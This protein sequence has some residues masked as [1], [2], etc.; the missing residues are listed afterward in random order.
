MVGFA[1]RRLLP[2]DVDDVVSAAMSA[3]VVRG[4]RSRSER[5]LV[6]Y[7]LY[8]V[9]SSI[10]DFHRSRRCRP[11]TVNFVMEGLED[12]PDVGCE[13]VVDV[14]FSATLASVLP[15][16]QMRLAELL[17]D[18]HTMLSASRELGL[19]YHSV[20]VLREKMRERL[21]PLAVGAPR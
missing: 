12:E 20:K 21:V 9:R 10:A 4:D 16:L 13:P 15:D 11:V 5:E 2:D 3:F 18:G 14:D 1:V 8:C 17:M 7:A 6:S 19:S